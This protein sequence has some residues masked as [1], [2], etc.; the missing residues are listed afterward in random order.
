MSKQ[1]QPNEPSSD[2]FSDDRFSDY[3][4]STD[5]FSDDQFNADSS[6]IELT[7]QELDQISGGIDLMFSSTL[8]E[9][10][11][12]FSGQAIDSDCGSMRSVS[13]SSRT[14]FSSWQFF[15][16]GFES[17]GEALSFISGLMKLFGR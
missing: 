7:E 4:Y 3:Q 13:S 12:E 17:V 5:R 14:S 10:V 8:F 1:T 9:Q 11:D 6:P 15:G 16:S 2:R